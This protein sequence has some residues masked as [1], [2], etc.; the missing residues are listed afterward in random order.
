MWIVEGLLFPYS[1]LSTSKKILTQKIYAT[2]AH[3]S[4]DCIYLTGKVGH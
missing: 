4:R 2:W 1:L 3:V